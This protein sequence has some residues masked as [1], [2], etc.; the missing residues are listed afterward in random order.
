[1][2]TIELT[3]ADEAKVEE[4]AGSLF[5]ACLATMELANVELGIRLGLYEALAR[6]G[7]GDARG[8]RDRDRHRRAVRAGVARAAGGRGCR[9][10]RRH[11]RRR[12]MSVGSSC[13]NAHAHVLLDDDSEACMKPCAA[14]V[15]W[16]AKA[17][18]IMVEEFRR[19][20]RRGVRAVRP[21]RRP[22]RVHPSGVREPP[23]PALAAGAARRAGEADLGSTRCGSPRSAAVRAVAAITIARAYPNV[24]VDGYRPRRGVDR[25]RTA[26]GRRRGRRR[27]GAVRARDAADPADRRRLRPRHGDRD[28]PRRARPGR[29]PPHDEDARRRRRRGARRRRAD[30]GRRSRCRPTRWS[31]SSTRSARCT[32]SRSA[33]RTAAR[34]PAP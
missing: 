26:R 27:S 1:M 25:R 8:A 16:V 2:S 29:H 14:V 24:E 20:T 18:D 19:G 28:A 9:R 34:A 7:A 15:P 3:A 33:C 11:R 32:A 22:G 4:F 23:D 30:R 31:A 5:V 10:G 6:R 17:I 12:R 13:P 21:A